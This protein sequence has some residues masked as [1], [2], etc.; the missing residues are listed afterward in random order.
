[1]NIGSEEGNQAKINEGD[2]S[3]PAVPPQP[4]KRKMKFRSANFSELGLIIII[5]LLGMVLTKFGGTHPDRVTGEP[6]S[7][8]L[9][10]DA[11]LDAATYASYFA[12]MAVGMTAVIITAGI[13]L[14]VGSLYAL[15]GVSTALVLEGMHN[16]HNPFLH[17]HWVILMVGLV[18]CLGVGTLGGL[19][20]GLATVLLDVHPFI[21]TLGTLWIFRGLAFVISKAMSIQLPSPI[22]NFVKMPLGLHGGLA[23]LPVVVL[24]I[25]MTGGWVYLTKTPMGRRV[26]AVGGNLE[27]SRYAGL[28]IKNIISGVYVLTGLCAGIAAFLAIGYYGSASSADGTGYELYVIAAAVVGGCSLMGGRGTVL[29]TVLGAVLI[30]MIRESIEILHLNVNY[31]QIIVGLAIILAVV[32]DRASTKIRARYA[33]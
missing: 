27:A 10:I 16:S 11:L 25:V 22:V 19:I 31:E 29:G 3:K 24:L 21:I 14:S 26:F 15:S 30:E 1:M 32:I 2:G 8:F 18:C 28:P 33:S 17:L 23:P 12:I 13:D 9:N 4:I 20:N 7:N 6:V 5:I